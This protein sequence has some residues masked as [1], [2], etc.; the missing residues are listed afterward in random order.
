MSPRSVSISWPLSS[1][2]SSKR[3]RLI[4]SRARSACSLLSASLRACGGATPVFGSVPMWRR[5]SKMCFLVHAIR[6]VASLLTSRHQPAAVLAP[7][8]KSMSTNATQ[9]HVVAQLTESVSILRDWELVHVRKDTGKVG[10]P[11][12]RVVHRRHRL[13]CSYVARVTIIINHRRLRR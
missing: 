11:T 1:A 12:P 3:C 8:G 5:K 4:S 9:P 7:S 13:N 2:R 10:M 6:S